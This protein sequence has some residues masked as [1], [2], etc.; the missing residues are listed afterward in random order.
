MKLEFSK[1]LL[2]WYW[3]HGFQRADKYNLPLSGWVHDLYEARD[4][5][6]AAA[7]SSRD[8]KPAFAVWGPS[9]T[10]KS[11][12][13]SAY[14]DRMSLTPGVEG[15]DG[16]NSALYWP[17]G[18]PGYFIMPDEF[19]SDPPPWINLL[20][21]FRLG[22]D[23]SACLSRFT[24]GSADAHAGPLLRPVAVVSDRNQIA[25]PNRI[26]ACARARL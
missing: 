16:K 24:L 12:L 13:V 5:I 22:K 4:G 17:G 18:L 8:T 26:A 15:E 1:G 9:Q 20:N 2:K 23:A 10:G 6:D 14:F 11:M 25:E 19:K 21:P 3:E 7:E